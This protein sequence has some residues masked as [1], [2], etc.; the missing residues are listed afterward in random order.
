VELARLEGMW[1][2]VEHGVRQLILVAGEPGAG[3]SRLVMEAAWALHTRGVPVLVGTCTSDFGLPF[4]P[5]VPPVRA[6]LA[7]VDRGELA[8]AD[9]EGA[10]ATQARDLLS[11]LISGVSSETTAETFAAAA[12]GAVVSA[13]SSACTH[14]PVVMVLEDVH[15]AGESGLRAL[16][17]IVERTADLPVL[18]LVTHRDTPPDASAPLSVL[19]AE[20]MRLP[21]VHRIDIGGFDTDDVSSYLNAQK[22]GDAAT[23]R[24]G[25]A[26]LRDATGGNPFL[27]GELWREL[28]RHGGLGHLATGQV[29][30]PGSL[31]VLVRERL[32]RLDPA[33]RDVVARGAVIGETFGVELVRASG[34]DPGRSV[35]DIFRALAAATAQGLVGAVPGSVGQYRFAHALARQAVLEAMD[36]YERA[37]AHA[38]IAIA[39]EGGSDPA[40]AAVL[41]QLA[42]HFS[43][44]VGLGLE[45]RAAQYLEKSATLAATRL[46]HSD[47][48]ALLERAADLTP[49]GRERDE[50]LIRAA[51]SHVIAGHFRRA[52]TLDEAL[53]TTG[54]RD[55]RLRAAVDYEEA[56]YF[57]AMGGRAVDL[58]AAA[59]QET[60]LAKSDPLRVLGEAAYG[61]A[62]V[63]SGHSAEG[64]AQL[65]RAVGQARALADERLL[66]AV[67][68]RCITLVVNLTSDG[69]FDRMLQ[70]RGYAHE[71]ATI[72]SRRGELRSLGYALMMQAFTAYILGD[73]VKLDTAIEELVL[74][75]R[76]SNEALF[77]WRGILLTTTRQLLQGEFGSARASLAEGRRLGSTMDL[78]D[79]AWSLQ[80]FM[81]RREAGGL[82]FAR[83][84][85]VAGKTPHNTWIPGLLALCTELG[86]TSRARTLLHG[87]VEQ[88]LTALRASSTW[89]AALSFLAD[90]TV[91]LGDRRCAEILISEAELF[92]GLNLMS[93]EFLAAFGSAHRA[94]A[95][96][97]AVLDRPGVED[98]FAAALEMDTHM[99]STLHIATTRAEW[100]AWLRRTHAPPAR[101]EEQAKHA[102][103]LA[104]RHGLVRVRRLLGEDGS[105]LPGHASHPDGLT[106]RELEVLRLICRGRSNREIASDLFISEHTAANHV[107]SILMKTQS[108]NRTAAARYAMGHGLLEESSGDSYL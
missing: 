104:E 91:S 5:L 89:P 33:D 54:D 84:T 18:F 86:L 93:S 2:A 8:L 106:S 32:A 74:T 77:R 14:G 67:L 52:R 34:L 92:A 42:H 25:A 80:S 76:V 71:L 15:W 68:T 9:A 4:D 40:D 51:R 29:A 13:L 23:I 3:K 1:A 56:S 94:L 17:Y 83:P 16:R 70:E 47:A 27:L 99:G 35:A 95:G 96:L 31:L 105:Q 61:R 20:L 87:S 73:R 55:V 103:D 75:G 81:I 43:M 85:L 100:A 59:L 102:R 26:M 72:A 97:T 48:A 64:H 57:G 62:L 6:L 49:V 66:L 12:L 36:P 79:G 69:D 11:M 78:V 24:S 107:R 41:P 60:V 98:H 19:T 58:L 28:Q 108:A 21:G 39:I 82:E 38:A 63:L 53:A 50:L 10:S 101:Q 7:A 46:A 90:A 30:V 65:D 22:A 45:R 88:G 44:A 37:S